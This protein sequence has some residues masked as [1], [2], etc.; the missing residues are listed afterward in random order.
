MRSS[1]VIA[2]ALTLGG[3]AWILSG[4]FTPTDRSAVAGKVDGG[5]S[6]A[7]RPQVSVRV[8]TL[9]ALMHP[10]EISINGRTAESR[11]VTLRAE[12]IGPIADIFIQEGR[13]VSEN[14][15]IARQN[16]EDRTALLSEASAL[17]KQR[18]IEFSAATELA[19][20]GFRS[21]TKLAEAQA[22]LEAAQARTKSVR[23]DISRTSIRA[24]FAGVL[25][26]LHVEKGDYVQKGGEIATVVDLDPILA[27]GFVSERDVGA[28]RT[29]TPGSLRLLD[30][31]T[32]SGTVRFVG[33]VADAATRSFR[34]EL[35]IPNPGNL[36][37]AGLTSELRLPLAPVS[38]H[39]VSPAWLTLADD[40]TI[41]LRGVNTDNTV[42]FL[43][44]TIIADT[45]EGMW[46]AGVP[47]R[48]RVITVGHEY[49]KAGQKVMP[50]PDT[51]NTPS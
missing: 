21:G 11:H 41:G 39:L 10:R 51:G 38:A 22:Q 8:R 1:L 36:I 40:G 31:R 46:V 30:G 12:T 18:Q 7:E 20:K 9:T 24:P 37:R 43:P 3:A 29:G 32:A 35:E 28:I 25:E 16:I 49:V 42:V 14:E 26:T 6:A 23:I 27:V 34:V 15:V 2:A 19:R 44:V 48:I 17:E 45:P 47:D 50:V 5:F 13:V 33:S 4:Q